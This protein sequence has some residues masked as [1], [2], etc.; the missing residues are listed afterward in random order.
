M[1]SSFL[2]GQ[3]SAAETNTSTTTST[4]RSAEPRIVLNRYPEELKLQC[5]SRWGGRIEHRAGKHTG[6]C[7][8]W[9]LLPAMQLQQC[10][11][12]PAVLPGQDEMETQPV[13]DSV[14]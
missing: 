6:A 9:Q 2:E 10:P 3:A 1:L 11:P 14:L 13:E 5:G 12:R 8:R 4:A 7:R